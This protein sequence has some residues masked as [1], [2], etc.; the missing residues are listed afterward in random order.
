M[1]YMKQILIIMIVL[2]KVSFCNA[3]YSKD[4]LTDILTGSSVKSWSIKG[5]AGTYAFNKNRTVEIKNDKGVAKSEKWSLSSADNIR[6][7][8]STNGHKYELIV[9]YDKSGKQYIKLNSQSGD[10]RASGYS[11]IVL[12]P[13]L[14]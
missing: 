2:L 10:S 13:I 14:K 5:S 3:Q 1:N 7:F 8:I 4:K 9:S 12:Y 6:W 11:E